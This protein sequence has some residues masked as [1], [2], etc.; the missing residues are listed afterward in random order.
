[1][2]RGEALVQLVSQSEESSRDTRTARVR[3]PDNPAG[4][5]RALIHAPDTQIA[6]TL[7]PDR[8]DGSAHVR[9]R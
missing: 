8:P 4:S 3:T 1:M 6:R 9:D 7:P 5:P 2:M